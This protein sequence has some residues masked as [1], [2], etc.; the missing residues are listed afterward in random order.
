MNTKTQ[1]QENSIYLNTN[2]NLEPS[3]GLFFHIEGSPFQNLGKHNHL[4]LK[5]PMWYLKTILKRG[6]KYL[7]V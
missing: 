4:K 5:L 3:L 1:G 6:K 2:Y 7:P